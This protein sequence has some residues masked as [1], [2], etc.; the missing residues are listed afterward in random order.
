VPIDADQSNLLSTWREAN[1]VHLLLD[2]E[3][4]MQ[5]R[6]LLLSRQETG[7]VQ[8]DPELWVLQEAPVPYGAKTGSKN[9]AN[10]LNLTRNRAI[11]LVQSNLF[12]RQE[13]YKKRIG[14]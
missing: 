7:L 4:R 13:N 8:A 5:V 12:W 14:K 10:G 11:P 2:A 6:P 1:H 3:E 9:A